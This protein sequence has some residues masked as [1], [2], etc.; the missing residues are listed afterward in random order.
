M[1]YLYSPSVK[2]SLL[3]H[4]VAQ[5]FNESKS[6]S[7]HMQVGLGLK[8]AE[9]P[10]HAS[11]IPKAHPHNVLHPPSYYVAIIFSLCQANRTKVS[12]SSSSD[13]AQT[14]EVST[15]E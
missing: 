4:T 5:R 13:L 2:F 14:A 9:F 7:F 15:S 11:S 1:M 10:C 12:E 8:Y 6:L 3:Q